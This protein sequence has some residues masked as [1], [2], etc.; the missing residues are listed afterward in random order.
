M[1]AL[2]PAAS[3]NTARN[4]LFTSLFLFNTEEVPDISTRWQQSF[5][6]TAALTSQHCVLVLGCADQPADAINHLALR[7]QLFLLGLLAEENH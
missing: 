3:C 1:D 7:V 2:Q 4:S 5:S 6:W